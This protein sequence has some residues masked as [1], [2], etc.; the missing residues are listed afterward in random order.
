MNYK[1]A[2][3][4]KVDIEGQVD[5]LSEQLGNYKQYQ[6]D[7]GL[8][9]EDVRNRSDYK[10]IK[11]RYDNMFIILQEYNKWFLKEFKKEYLK[12]RAELKKKRS[13]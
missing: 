6:N 3:Q 10:N 12:E 9:P 2:K 11:L 7:M 13:R 1:E 4:K 8:L 5:Y